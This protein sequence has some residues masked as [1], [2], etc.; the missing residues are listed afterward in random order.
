MLLWHAPAAKAQ[1]CCP[2]KYTETEMAKLNGSAKKPVK[3][4]VKNDKSAKPVL[5][6]KAENGAAAGVKASRK[7]DPSKSAKTVPVKQPVNTN[8]KK[9]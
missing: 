3:Q 9:Q 2:D 7:E 6:A 1:D 8:Q 5:V 4:L